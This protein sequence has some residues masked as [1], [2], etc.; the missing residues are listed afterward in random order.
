MCIISAG[1]SA[2]QLKSKESMAGSRP[3]S[4]RAR[5]SSITPAD[6]ATA[7][8]AAAAVTNSQEEVAPP[9]EPTPVPT[10]SIFMSVVEWLLEVK[11]M[12]VSNMYRGQARDVTHIPYMVK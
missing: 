7:T 10:N 12:P 9:R 6:G 3:S 11:A 1:L 5:S 8:E 4:Q 2:S